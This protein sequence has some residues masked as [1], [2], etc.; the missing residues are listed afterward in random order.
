[1]FSLKKDV[2]WHILKKWK[3]GALGRNKNLEVPSTTN[4]IDIDSLFPG[5]YFI[6]TNGPYFQE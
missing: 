2:L 1:M 4:G 6:E 3:G 5:L